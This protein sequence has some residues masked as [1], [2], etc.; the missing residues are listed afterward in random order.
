MS[1]IFAKNIQWLLKILPKCFFLLK[2]MQSLILKGSP[3]PVGQHIGSATGRCAVQTSSWKQYFFLIF[4][5]N[6]LG[7]VCY[8]TRTR[9]VLIKSQNRASVEIK[10]QAH[11]YSNLFST[12]LTNILDIEEQW[13]RTLRS[14]CEGIDPYSYLSGP[15]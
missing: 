4:S 7:K 8:T 9:K 14:N 2:N 12:C 3:W 5:I 13:K 1:N 6:T 10:D 15:T 11:P